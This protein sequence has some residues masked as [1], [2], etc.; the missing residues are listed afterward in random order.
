MSQLTLCEEAVRLLRQ[1]IGF[2]YAVIIAQDGSTP[3]ESGAKMLVLPDSI[4]GTIGGGPME[5]SVMATARKLLVDGRTMTVERY[6]MSGTPDANTDCICGGANEVLIARVDAADPMNLAVFEAAAKAE[7]VGIPAW[8]YYV[9]DENEGAEQ[10]FT[11][12][13]NVG[14]EITGRLHGNEK[15]M[16][17]LMSSP[18]HA[19][20]HGEKSDG[21]RY[22]AD[23]VGMLSVMYLFG[24]GH[25][26]VEVARLAVNLGF[27][28][29]VV[30]DRDEFAN[31][32]RF[33][34]CDCVVLDDFRDMPNF[35]T[36][37]GTYLLIITRGHAHDRTVLEW[38]LKKEAK[39]VGMIGSHIKRDATYKAL[40]AE[41]Y[42]RDRLRAVACPIGNAIGA[43]TPAEIAVSI[44]AELI[45]VRNLGKIEDKQ[46][47]L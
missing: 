11:L 24:G 43:K 31:E 13:A 46:A 47:G 28:V 32:Q 30:D 21:V 1:G 45:Q 27:R 10:P 23:A 18:L 3:R 16:R 33:P 29:T 26:S 40:L 25:V 42:D 9:I 39:Y 38:A 20:V 12:A 2:A 37:G 8:L 41:G 4:V 35:Q 22:V 5:G 36:G 15:R 17:Y 14:G 6:D 19:A 44:M 7:Y 34:G